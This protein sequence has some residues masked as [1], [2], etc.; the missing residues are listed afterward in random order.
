MD[1]NV[2][3]EKQHKKGK[4]YTR[5]RLDLLFDNGTYSELTS[6]ENRDGV[7]VC[8]GEISGKKA[9]VAAQDF[10]WKGGSLGRVH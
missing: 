5:E 8:T 4:L 7:W 10:T 6:E 2:L 3:V 9:V 1:E